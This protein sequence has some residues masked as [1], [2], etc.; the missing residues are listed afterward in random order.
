MSPPRTVRSN[1]R[2]LRLEPLE[3]RELLEAGPLA[4]TLEIPSLGEDLG[5]SSDSVGETASEAG[6]RPSV[7][8]V[9]LLGAGTGCPLQIEVVFSEAMDPAAVRDPANYFVRREGETPLPVQSVDYSEAD[10]RHR[11]TLTLAET[12]RLAPGTYEVSV[13][14]RN[15]VDLSGTAMVE[16]RDDLA[17]HVNGLNALVHVGLAESGNFE[18][19]GEP[20]SYG[21][22]KPR[23][24]VADDFTGDGI[25]DLVSLSAATGEL[26]FLAGLGENRYS[27][28]VAIDLSVSTI[29]DWG[30]LGGQLLKGD[31]N[32]DGQ[33]DLVVAGVNDIE[34]FLCDG[35]GN[36]TQAPFM[37]I[38]RPAPE[39]QLVSDLTGD[40]LAD[41]VV[42]RADHLTLDILSKSPFVGY[43]VV[44]SLSLPP[45]VSY[46]TSHA[47]TSG[48][49]TG[50]GFTDLVVSHVKSTSS[51]YD[52][53]ITFFRGSASGFADGEEISS[54]IAFGPDVFSADVNKDGHLDIIATEDRT[55]YSQ[56]YNDG[57][58]IHVLLGDGEGGFSPRMFAF[59]TGLY[60][61]WRSYMRIGCQGA[62]LRE[63]DDVNNDGSPDLIFS[64]VPFN[65]WNIPAEGGL[66][67]WLGDGT[68]SFASA[69]DVPVRTFESLFDTPITL[70]DVN[71]DG[72]LDGILGRGVESLGDIRFVFGD[73]AG[74]FIEAPEDAIE[75]GEAVKIVPEFESG[76]AQGDYP[77]KQ[78]Q[79]AD[80]N[81]DGLQDWT[82]LNGRYFAS[83][84]TYLSN[85]EGGWQ[86]SYTWQTGTVRWIE[87]GDLNRDGIVD[88]VAGSS[89]VVT[90]A[91]SNEI[92][93]Y[94]GNGDGSFDPL[95]GP[96]FRAEGYAICPD[97]KLVDVNQ[98]GNLDLVVSLTEW[99]H[100]IGYSY[101]FPV[102]YAVFFGDGSGRLAFNAY[103][104]V[105]V[106]ASS[107]D[108]APVNVSDYDFDGIPDLLASSNDTLTI[109]HGNGN[110]TFS[111]GQTSSKTVSNQDVLFYHVD[112][113][114][115]GNQDL[116][117]YDPGS[118]LNG[119]WR[120]NDIH[121]YLGDGE[122]YYAL[123]TDRD[124][125]LTL[126][127]YGNRVQGFTIGDFDANG[128][129]DIAVD[130]APYAPWNAEPYDYVEIYL[131]DGSG[132]FSDV[133]TVT[134]GPDP[135]ALVTLPQASV[136]W[137]GSFSVDELPVYD[138][139][140]T[141]WQTVEDID[142]SIG[143]MALMLETSR[144]GFL[145]FEA[146][147]PALSLST[148]VEASN[149]TLK[150]FESPDAQQP[151]AV[152]TLVAGRQRID[153]NVQ[154]G[155]AYYF[156]LSG[157]ARNV[158][159]QVANLV[160]RVGSEVT[161]VGTEDADTFK[162]SA[163][164]ICRVTINGVDY[165]FTSAEADRFSFDGFGGTDEVQFIGS[166]GR[167]HATLYPTSGKFS[168]QGY[169]LTASNIESTDYDGG[170]G[171][172]TV[173]IWG[174]KGTNQYTANPGFGE[175]TGDGVS[176][177]VTA[178]TI[179]ARGNGGSDTVYFSDS[180]GDDLLQYYP[181]WAIMSGEGY[182]NQVNAFKV[183]YADAERGA[184]G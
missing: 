102:G 67:V 166:I 171:E 78:I 150:L 15:L 63:I 50:D 158:D 74:G 65:N 109:W 40:G 115:D 182:F 144:A 143:A 127:G 123:S 112:V 75:L 25:V 69:T 43:D 5:G 64:V 134:V 142:L 19:I 162:F 12:G 2:S 152:S 11:A 101:A 22:D 61:E 105:A 133:R 126:R 180:E 108:H 107:Q 36:F 53:T 80:L 71:G 42:M 84:A 35:Q 104:V 79:V 46:E 110:G 172:D 41:I 184:G 9:E 24:I 131:S 173:T 26:V 33:A 148:A 177:S 113:D 30:R 120:V 163:G 27:D 114:G 176:I 31:W 4:A 85:S 76:V 90:G 28:P 145:T 135:S 155:E 183:M 68:G 156:V 13:E 167:D 100:A 164:D 138:W 147:V 87:M 103:T 116:L 179:Y 38:P 10:G 94:L 16:A 49:F 81:A 122:G 23:Q 7:L 129:I 141:D 96:P 3:R 32:G 140:V 8:G 70:D 89:V 95:P 62:T 130:Y 39:I 157:T 128:A 137:V 159:L 88:I 52:S 45:V 118:H 17:V 73:G 21:F 146:S 98:D 99:R 175:M 59:K 161:I 165:Q 169:S 86:P 29:G 136:V 72:H 151:L 1:F 119:D 154:A 111:T 6:T 77:Q 149:V 44:Q 139:G 174:S 20:R 51:G 56:G 97:G 117:G 55:Y 124:V 121:V 18:V 125:R 48:D 34:V 153:W 181:R 170:D 47:L 82:V 37:P 14:G 91:D 92:T 57:N 54:N 83:I 106:E 178:E 160:S 60:T 66:W 93:V 168:G 58:V 132:H